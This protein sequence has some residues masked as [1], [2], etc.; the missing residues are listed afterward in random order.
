MARSNGLGTIK[1]RADGRWE[2]Q[3]SCGIDSKGKAIRKSIYGR[4]KKDVE[5]KLAEITTDQQRCEFVVPEKITYGEWLKV[6]QQE[7]LGSVKRST[8]T[9]YAYHVN[10]NII[11]ALGR[12]KLQKITTPMI[13]SLYNQKQQGGLAAKTIKNLHG[14]I[15]KSFEQACKVGY[16]RVNPSDAAILPKVVKREMIIL[17]DEKIK[18]FLSEIQGKKNEDIFFVDLWTGLR[19]AEIIGLTWDCIDFKKKVIRVEKQ[20]KRKG[21][22]NTKNHY[23]F[24]TLKN[25]KTRIVKPAPFVF[26]RLKKVRAKQAE[27]KLKYGQNF[28]NPHNLVFTNELGNH[29]GAECLLKCFKVRAK[30]I[31]LPKMRFH[32][33]RHTWVVMMLESGVNIKTVSEM[34]GHATVAFTLDVYGHVTNFMMDDAAN[35]V[36]TF[37]EAL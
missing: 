37:Y 30:H 32:D 26:D 7:Y 3:Y 21:N 8:A 36:Q 13:Q 24:D 17:R 35:K 27:N 20:L 1:K 10:Q 18:E 19:E 22:G 33:L 28:Q 12:F 31:G 16:L 34:A 6:W 5:L 14:V 2:G 29:I 9:N 23:E 25:E 11:P 15:H 4:T